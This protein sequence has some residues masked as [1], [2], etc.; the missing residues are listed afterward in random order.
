[1]KLTIAILSFFVAATAILPRQSYGQY[2][3]V[4]VYSDAAVS[5]AYNTAPGQTGY[6]TYVGEDL[7]DVDGKSDDCKT[8][9][10][11]DCK[12]NSC[13]G[14][15]WAQRT[16][17]GVEYLQ[18]WNKGRTIPP[19]VTGGNPI[20]TPYAAAGVLP[21]APVLFGGNQVGGDLKAGIRLTAG[22][23]L[24][25]CE[26]T[27]I[28]VRGYGTE[29]DS[30]QY[31]ATS[32][33]NPILATPFV[34]RSAAFFG[35]NNA[36]VLAYAGG[37]TPGINS[38][39]SVSAVTAN[40]IWGGDIYGR[41]LIDEGCDYRLDLLGGYQMARIDDDLQLNTTLQRLDLAGAPTFSTRD[42]FDVENEY[43]AGTLGM[44][45]EFYNGPLTI[46]MMGKLGIGNMNQR[47]A[48][49]GSNVAAGVA[50]GGG[51]FAQNQAANGGPTFNVGN[52]Q[53]NL[54]VW[55]PEASIKASYGV[56]ERLSVTVGYTL[57]YWT[58]VALAGDQVDV[59]VNRDVMF[60]GNYLPGG[61]AAPT[62]AFRDTDMWVQTIDIGLLFNY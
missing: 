46:Q 36:L 23:W 6:A 55:S 37:A 27:A 20:T 25:D 43:H 32:L 12:C 22:L 57:L 52:Y 14:S 21:G 47:V 11:T 16:F 49:S 13:Q 10:K 24:D 34:D 17:V 9:G 15:N 56:T 58:R 54:L 60:N 61:G 28:V 53:R 48:I 35:Q 38:Q 51:I 59:N 4:P 41:T 40:D 18:W 39:G 30:S 42:L 5:E 50:S 62:F 8:G 29:G 2:A 44:L 3:W 31:N 45:G 33:G 1:M 26:T 7:E 19:I